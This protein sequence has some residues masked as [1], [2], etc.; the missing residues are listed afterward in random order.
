MPE[1]ERDSGNEERMRTAVEACASLLGAGEA[2]R[3][4]VVAGSVF[5][6]CLG[7][8]GVKLPSVGEWLRLNPGEDPAV[9]AALKRC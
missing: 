5:Q 2:A 9:A 8:H 1:D 3:V 7:R 6:E 4:P